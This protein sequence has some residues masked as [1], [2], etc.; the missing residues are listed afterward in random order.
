MGNWECVLVLGGNG[1]FASFTGICPPT[2]LPTTMGVFF[3][4]FL[5]FCN[6]AQAVIIHQM[7]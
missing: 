6:L 4:F 7:I 1:R 5:Q 3:F 2:A